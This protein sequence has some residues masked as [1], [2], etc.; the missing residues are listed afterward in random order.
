MATAV[1]N[2]N[3]TLP[4]S[5]VESTV[6]HVYIGI[7]LYSQVFPG[8]SVQSVYI[9]YTWSCSSTCEGKCTYIGF[10]DMAS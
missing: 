7:L 10:T 9:I 4:I 3:N 2:Y 5:I 6:G 8:I 1:F